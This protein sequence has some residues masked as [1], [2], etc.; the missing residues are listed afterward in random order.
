LRKQVA[1]SVRITGATLT[2][3]THNAGNLYENLPGWLVESG[4]E[5][6]AMHSPDESLQALFSSLMKMHRGE[7]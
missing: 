5:V 1:D 3:A 4:L 6:S 2:V 7:L